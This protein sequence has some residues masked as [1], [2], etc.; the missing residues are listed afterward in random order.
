MPLVPN[1]LSNYVRTLAP[2]PPALTGS[3]APESVDETFTRKILIAGFN[4]PNGGVVV[5]AVTKAEQAL[6]KSF[7][8]A[9]V[10][11]SAS[12]ATLKARLRGADP[13]I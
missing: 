10:K 13:K 6:L 2:V 3:S 7:C 9:L 8:C 1:V 12:M 5:K 11:P 4:L